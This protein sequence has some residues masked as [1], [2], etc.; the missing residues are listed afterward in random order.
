MNQTPT[1]Q[2][3][4]WSLLAGAWMCDWRG[5]IRTSW[6]VWPDD[7]RLVKGL[8]AEFELFEPFRSK[9]RGT[10][11]ELATAMRRMF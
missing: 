6:E 9:A 1:F 8:N 7:D 11:A 4:I 10:A 2:P 3:S 5:V